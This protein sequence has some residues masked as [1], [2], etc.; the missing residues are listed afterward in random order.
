MAN[1][2]DDLRH[3]LDSALRG[4]SAADLSRS[5]RRLSDR[6]REA[7]AATEPI[8]RSTT[9]IAT[10]AAYRMPATFTAVSAAL[11][12]FALLDP[13]C[14]PGTQLDLGGG[15]GAAVW[16]AAAIWPGLRAVTVVEQVP[17]VIALARQL[18]ASAGHPAVRGTDWRRGDAADLDSLP[19]ADLVTVSYL[20]G[21]L[22]PDRRDR[23][24]TRLAAHR[25]VIALIE[26]GTPAGYQRIVRARDQLIASGLT[27][28]APCPHD[29]ECPIPRDRDWCHF[30]ARVNR[31][32]LHRRAKEAT[33]GFE[34][35]KFSYV[36]A[37]PGPGPRAANRVL[38][39]PGQRKGLVSLRLCTGSDGLDEQLVSKRQ[40]DRYRAAR[41][42]E[43]GDAWPPDGAVTPGLPAR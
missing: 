37:A 40:G 29:R 7:T 16:A 12:Q 14:H 18:A 31:S 28:R 13:A 25:G 42:A 8:L 22:D 30:A 4:T 23:L 10:Y 17:E 27:V 32:A 35:E 6:Y 1:L 34:D 9:D 33:L 20:L 5:F 3:A 24:V 39:H 43:W 38:R 21:E 2:P 11:G 26:P 36:I 19:A 15:T 41:D